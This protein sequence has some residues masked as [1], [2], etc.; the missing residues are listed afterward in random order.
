MHGE[1]QATLLRSE[2]A[3]RRIGVSKSW[4]EKQRMKGAAE[5]RLKVGGVRTVAYRSDTLDAW[6]K[7]HPEYRY[8]SEAAAG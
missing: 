3:A 6:L 2:D 1:F 8:T 5:L 7:S 4:L